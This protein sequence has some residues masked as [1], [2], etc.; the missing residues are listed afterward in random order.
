[1]FKKAFGVLQKVGKALMLPVALL[2]A[3]GILL[4][5]GN[6]LQN[7]ALLDLAPFLENGGVEM[8]ASVMENA[9]NIVF[10]NL[11]LLFA[12]GVAV[13][14]AGGEGVAALAAIIGYLIMN[15]TMGTVLGIEA[16]DLEGSMEYA[17]V[18]GIPTLQTGV[19]GGI[20]VGI[21][22]ASM[23]NK[24]FEIELPSYLG[25]FAGKRFV[26]IATAASAVVLGLLMIII[27]P[28]IQ[29]ALNA[30]SQNMV[31]ANLTLSAFV[32]GVIERSLIPFGLHHIFYSPFW[33]EFGQYTTNAG[34]LVR[35]DQ[36]IF[37]A[38]IKD[39]VQD[40][41]AGTFMTGK[42]PFMMFGL[43]AAALAIYHEARPERK[44][45]VGGL[46]ASAALTSF[47]TGITEPLEFSFLFVAPVLFGIHAIFAG[48]SFMT[49]HLLDVKIG[50]TFSGGLIDYILF[51]LI[52]P[53]TN[54]W[55]VI[56]V[57]IVF[58]VIY[59][60]GFRFAIRKFNLKTP[61]RED[62][63]EEDVAE[64][65][66][67]GG[68]LPYQILEA[69]GGQ[70]NISHLD[71]CITRLRV[72]VNDIK[73]VD[74]NRL[75]KLGASGVLEVGNNIQA[76]F[77][78]RSETI[79]G[80]MKDI[81]TGKK[82]RPAE[83]APEKGVEQQIE[84]VNPEALQTEHKGE[85]VFVSPIK[86][87]I[88]PITDVPDAVFSGKMM[89]DGFA[90]VPSEGTIVS[91][92]DGKIVN[93]FP[94]KHALGLLSDSGREIL[95]H[96]GIDT[97]NLKGQGFETLVKEN[98]RVEKGQPLLKVDLDFVKE[99]APSIMTPIVFTNLAEGEAV[100]INKTGSVDLK[101]EDIITIKK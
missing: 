6:A 23:Y 33:Y 27:W 3:A 10:S 5:F 62:V 49:M 18:L 71:A 85:D 77:G 56:P 4:A 94:T 28:P 80:Q 34:E 88:K 100:V 95:I 98:D 40:L 41:S 83:K 19:F 84:E 91:P 21:L 92:V 69:M 22:A 2:P 53:Q 20:I 73:D 13:G 68:D 50:M 65:E 58:A 12:V 9:G 79:K 81:M 99:N 44:A 55:I 38:E 47:L 59:Y 57:G 26:P 39:R 17:N 52:N 7:P 8:V 43:P 75:K 16:K 51:G 66:N 32:F 87:E 90:I 61:G 64:G 76:I 72:S 1:M 86:G 67:K 29:S 35:G 89:G 97:V 24:F 11:A 45:I 63:E 42:F 70:E 46:M 82:P 14:L 93:L 37:M 25:F 101:E 15:V 54:A 74:K 60:F 31:H 78:P 36:R 48:L 30:F 96:V